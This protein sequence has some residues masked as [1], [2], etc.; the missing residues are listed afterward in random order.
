MVTNCFS[1]LLINRICLEICENIIKMIF[2]I[3]DETR[4]AF[5]ISEQSRHCVFKFNHIVRQLK[6][7]TSWQQ[8]FKLF[9]TERVIITCKSNHFF[10]EKYIK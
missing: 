5:S 1:Y 4:A 6:P 9:L 10:V 2:F 3:D 7:G 8:I